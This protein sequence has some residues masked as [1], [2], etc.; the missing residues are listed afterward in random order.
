M[1][2]PWGFPVDEDDPAQPGASDTGK[3][4]GIALLIAI[5]TIAM[6]MIFVADLIINSTVNLQLSVSSRDRIKAE[7]LAKSGF[8]MALFLIMADWGLDLATFQGLTGQKAMPTDGEGDP[9]SMLNGLPIGGGTVEMLSKVQESFD[10]SKVADSSVLDQMQ[11]FDGQFTVDVSDESAKINVNSCLQGRCD[12]TLELLTALFT[13]PAEKEFLARKKVI[14]K[15]LAGNIK[16]WSDSNTTAESVTDRSSESDPYQNRIPKVSPK[17][18]PYDSIDELKLVDG[19][20]DELH[21]I[22][23]PFLTIYP[24]QKN[25][26]DKFPINLNTAPRE[27]I[28]CLMPESQ[29]EGCAQKAALATNPAKEEDKLKSV[30][31]REEIGKRLSEYFCETDKK[32]AEYFTTRTDLF[33]VNVT[34][35]VGE[36]ERKLSI[37]V[38]REMPTAEDKRNN[39]TATYKVLDW[40]LL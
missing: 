37:V 29:K 32:K 16:D 9:W 14:P 12:Q 15:V 31:N 10:L 19:W 8:N 26:D 7:Y 38:L 1:R 40:K 18:A 36:Q 22:F 35:S 17:N 11:L 27:L 21:K 30:T 5:M 3:K 20:D 25:K 13:C 28:S 4:R 34:G 33:R 24:I 23:S 39:F 6:M 2:F